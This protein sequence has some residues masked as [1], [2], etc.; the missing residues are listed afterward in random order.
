MSIIEGV[1][2]GLIVLS[3]LIVVRALAE[4]KFVIEDGLLKLD[5]NLAEAIRNTVSQLQISDI[6]PINPIQ[7]VLAQFLMSK[8]EQSTLNGQPRDPAGQFTVLETKE[9]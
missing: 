5:Q 6:E 7:Q 1:I 4:L 3:T 9:N 2:I 8:V